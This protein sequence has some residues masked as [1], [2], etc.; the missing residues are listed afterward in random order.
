MTAEL[1]YEA[2]GEIS[3]S[4]IAETDALLFRSRQKGIH[5]LIAAC[6]TLLLLAV[7]VSAEMRTGYISNL[8]MPLYG[9]AQ[10]ELVDSVG[11]P[12]NATATVNGY[13]LSADAVIGDR[14]NIGITYTLRRDDGAALPED[15]HFDFIQQTLLRGGG[16]GWYS[17]K[18]SDDRTVM[19]V[20]QSLS[21]N[22]AITSFFRRSVTVSFQDLVTGSRD[23]GSFT[24]IQEGTWELNFAARYED[25]TTTIPVKDLVVHNSSGDQFTVHK[26]HLSPFGINIKLTVPNAG[27]GKPLLTEGA[28][29]E[30]ILAHNPRQ[31]QLSLRLTNGRLL[32]IE[33]GI[34]SGGSMDDPTH[35]G[36]YRAMF[37]QPIPLHTIAALVL[38]D[39]EYPLI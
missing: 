28:T 1:L 25:T 32:P 35:K 9:G 2:I 4:Y 10:T 38:C 37:D 12:I 24:V 34:G 23:D 39:T 36:T 16:G 13:T 14:Y 29:K 7:P 18:L 6:L 26:I 30:E 20:T 8:L 11:I 21:S 3:E 15:L 17:Q 22:N 5:H 27:Y 33:G 31:F 19:T